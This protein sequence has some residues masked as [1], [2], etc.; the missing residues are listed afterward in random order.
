MPIRLQEGCAPAVGVDPLKA[1]SRRPTMMGRSGQ[2]RNAVDV[3]RP[4]PERLSDW[5]FVAARRLAQ[6][7]STPARRKVPLHPGLAACAGG[8]ESPSV[9][10]SAPSAGAGRR[11]GPSGTRTAASGCVGTK[12]ARRPGGGMPAAPIWCTESDEIDRRHG[13]RPL[14]KTRMSR[15]DGNGD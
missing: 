5:G 9:T 10:L 7:P 4:T 2:E 13:R 15:A 3:S 8:Q 11:Q 1:G 6:A 14:R 12:M